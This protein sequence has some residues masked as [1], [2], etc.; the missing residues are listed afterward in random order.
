MDQ[1][2]TQRQIDAVW[3]KLDDT[4][5]TAAEALTLARHADKGFI[6]LNSDVKSLQRDVAKQNIDIN[7]LGNKFEDFI[8]KVQD[9]LANNLKWTIGFI[10]ML[11][12]AYAAI[13]IMAVTK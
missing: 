7:A 3:K 13:I 4:N 9:K 1:L 2:E 10:F 5:H 6:E 12:S 11:L 8:E